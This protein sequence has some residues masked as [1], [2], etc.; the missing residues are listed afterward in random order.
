VKRRLLVAIEQ[1]FQQYRGGYYTDI[2][3]PY[4][5]WREYL[6]YFAEVSVLARVQKIEKLPAHLRRADGEHVSFIALPDY[7]GLAR[8]IRVL[9]RLMSRSFHAVKHSDCI[10]LC[11]G[12][13]EICTWICTRLLRRDYAIEFIGDSYAAVIHARQTKSGA[14]DR[15]L[16]RLTH[17]LNVVQ[18]RNACAVSYVSRYLQKLYPNQNPDR[19][20]VF[21]DVFFTDGLKTRPRTQAE[22][23]KNEPVIIS[24]GRLMPEK[25]HKI[26]IEAAALL[27]QMRSDNWRI[28]IVGQGDE[29]KPLQD[30]IHSLGLDD[31]VKLVGLVKWGE[32]LFELLDN[33][34]LFVLPSFTEG[35]PR[36]LLEGM[37]RG[38]PAIA[39]RAGGITEVL[40]DEDLVPPGDAEVLAQRIDTVLDNPIRLE[41]MSRRNFDRA[42]EFRPEIMQ[43]RKH[44]FWQ[45]IIKYTPVKSEDIHA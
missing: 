16:A 6:E 23:A 31:H 43:Q 27:K 30:L 4:E 12:Y 38:L 35:M 39:S 18:A 45:S 5:D 21:S 1:R 26:L 44:S 9:P 29:E 2:A 25:G 20:F 33:A 7:Q 8:F 24:V 34:R 13:I 22:W 42:M 17:W 14:L 28:K 36:A 15:I 19:E 32:E 3:F 40:A 11:M 10:L 41:Q 37:A